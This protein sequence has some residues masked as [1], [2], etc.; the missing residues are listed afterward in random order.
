MHVLVIEDDPVIGKNVQKS[1]IEA[2]HTCE[3]VQ[4]GKRGAEL[5]CGTPA[6]AILLDLLLPDLEGLKVLDK[7]RERGIRTPVIILSALG[8]VEERVLGLQRGADDYLVKPFSFPE[9]LARLTAV[10]RRTQNRPSTMVQVGELSLDLS[11]RR[12]HREAKEIELSPTEFSILE[13]LM[14]FAGQVVT[15]KMLCE[16]LW[17]ADWEGT[18]NVVDVHINRLRTKVDRPFAHSLIQTVRGQ[19]YALQSPESGL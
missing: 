9:L 19:G 16:H 2:D 8:T 15:R 7:V 17:E 12:V 6:D 18:T 1:L 11:T 10:Q 13:F 14:R 4:T 3:W 5:A